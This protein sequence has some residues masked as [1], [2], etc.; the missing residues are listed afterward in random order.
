MMVFLEKRR[1][2]WER[3]SYS[4]LIPHYLNASENTVHCRAEQGKVDG[5]RSGHGHVSPLFC[6]TLLFT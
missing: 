4:R 2:L 5:V 3:L 6:T 1:G